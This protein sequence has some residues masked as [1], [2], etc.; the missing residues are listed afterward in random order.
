MHDPVD[1][2]PN[3]V[4]EHADASPLALIELMDRDGTVRQAWPVRRWP[5]TVGRAIDNTIVLD[6]PAVAAHHLR[7][8]PPGPEEVLPR[9][10][11]LPSLNGVH[12]G[13]LRLDPGASPVWSGGLLRAGHSSLRLRVRGER[14]APERPLAP[15]E[16]AIVPVLLAVLVMVWA[17]AAQWLTA[18]PDDRW[19]DQLPALLAWPLAIAAWSAGWALMSRLFQRR[20]DFVGHAGIA[21]RYL[22]LVL[23][24]EEAL[25]VLAGLLGWPL[26]SHLA[27]ALGLVVATLGLLAH[28]RRVWP[29]ASRWMAIGA[30]AAL[31]T[32][33]VLTV[34]LNRQAQDRWFSALYLTALP[35][36]PWNL[37]RSQDL[38]AFLEA[39]STLKE[40]VDDRVRRTADDL[41]RET[42][43]GPASDE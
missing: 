23:L 33:A 19:S 21:L 26:M 36:A 28:A 42:G 15:V 3:G 10:C 8:D 40:R 35:P 14:L 22:L 4:P 27:P 20:S 29:S 39:A 13:R 17:A 6:D 41:A 2:T 24:V 1:E 7:L 43:K 38:D 32:M 30:V 12:L 18:D 25:P 9:V 34:T 16:R 11:A 5:V 31:A 37:S